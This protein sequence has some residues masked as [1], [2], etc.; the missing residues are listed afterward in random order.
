MSFTHIFDG[1]IRGA[2]AGLAGCIINNISEQL[3]FCGLLYRLQGD[4]YGF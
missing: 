4:V 3:S 1:A 2:K